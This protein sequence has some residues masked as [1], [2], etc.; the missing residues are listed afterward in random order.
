MPQQ[1]PPVGRRPVQT[2]RRRPATTSHTRSATASSGVKKSTP[3]RRRKSSRR[4]I[5]RW[6]KLL[7]T[8]ILLPP[9]CCVLVNLFILATTTGNMAT[10]D[11]L[12]DADADCIVVLDGGQIAE[13]GSH[14]ELLAKK[15]AYYR[16]YQNQYAGFAT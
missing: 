2:P 4:R 14:E 16:L 8:I 7:I 3:P 15:G 5:P 13:A 10:P 6:L 11:E 9:V 1:H 12:A